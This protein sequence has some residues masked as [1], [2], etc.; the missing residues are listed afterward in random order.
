MLL[1]IFYTEIMV[2]QMHFLN[3]KICTE[4]FSL[5]T[6]VLST[7]IASVPSGSIL[8]LIIIC[9]S[10][11]IPSEEGIA[12][13]FVAEVVLWVFTLIVPDTLWSLLIEFASYF[14]N[15][16][17]V[18]GNVMT[19]CYGTIIMHHWS[20]RQ[21]SDGSDKEEGLSQPKKPKPPNESTPLVRWD[22][23]HNLSFNEFVPWWRRAFIWY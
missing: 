12:M 15:R 17:R 23:P 9:N 6:I 8:A 2:L 7:S 1:H 3:T 14:R 19:M 20:M 5:V 21:K 16:V 10:L 22:R 13:L 11:S 4:S 18:V